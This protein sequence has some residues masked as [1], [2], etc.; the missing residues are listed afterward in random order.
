V[1]GTRDKMRARFVVAAIA[2]LTLTAGCGG[3]FNTPN[4]P[5]V[6]TP[7]GGG[8]KPTQLVPVQVTV[9]LAVSGGSAKP[10]YLSPNTQSLAIQLASVDGNGVT[11][12]NPTT[13]N[14][15]PRAHDCRKKGEQLACTAT[16]SG[17]PGHDVFAATAY[18]STN[19]TG[20]VLS[21]GSVDATIGSGGG[22]FGVS[23]DLSL[24]LDGVIASLKLS[25]TPK[26]AKRGV[27][28]TS[29]V[30]LNGYDPSGAE[31]VGPSDYSAPIV[32]AIEG[33]TNRSFTL[34]D[35]NRSGQSL[36][37][38][39]PSG[40]ITLTYDGN[41]QA[42]PITVQAS[43]DGPVTPKSAGFALLGKQPPP[44]VGT[45]YA[46]NLG[47]DEG[48]S[49]TVTE[50]S[51]KAKGNAA[52]E[53]TLSLSNTLYATSIAVD[54][55]GNLY[56]GYLY[57]NSSGLLGYTAQGAPDPHNEIAIYAPDASGNDQPTATLV[58]DP[59][60]STTIFPAFISFDSSGDLVTFG[61]TTV[62]SITGNAVLTYK[63]GS[64]GPAQPE[65]GFNFQGAS[66][67][68]PGVTGLALD[69]AGDTYVNGTFK[70]GFSNVYGMYVA[71]A[72]ASGPYTVPAR[73]I[74]WDQY[75]GLNPGLTTNVSLNTS[76]EILIGNTVKTGSGGSSS[77]Q[78]AV[79]VF[80]AGATGGMTDNPPLRVLKLDDFATAGSGCSSSGS[81]LRNFFPEIQVYATALFA[82]DDFNNAVAEFPADKQGLV[83]PLLR[84]AGSATQLDHPIG[85]V[86][87]SVSGRAKARPVT[88]ARAG[89]SL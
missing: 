46:L 79:S 73:W 11:G 89:A 5:V 6:G 8:G 1:N 74:P 76:D 83:K 12:V 61:A 39:K 36:T 67:H 65:S 70:S 59:K 58:E 82:A 72:G 69:P 63:A 20:A 80:A 10:A 2:A 56:V 21:V 14:T 32:L 88:G 31:I 15:V 75:T 85:L 42:S 86:I 55:N 44:P 87:T 48:L 64:S 41:T 71:T 62:D 34:H 53:R 57:L 19:A 33:D 52:P 22:R 4:G 45:I 54:S 51:G 84:I 28:T 49:A 60:S 18:A 9:T 47:A 25:L 17:S 35:G 68:Y 16:A 23:N 26:D 78:A 27:R 40:G 37:I 77:C 66:L 13:I 29:S 24:A 7:G 50:Y 81:Q 38:T 43:A 30:T 3:S